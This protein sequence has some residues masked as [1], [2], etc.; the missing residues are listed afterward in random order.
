M[1]I[2]DSIHSLIVGAGFAGLYSLHRLRKLGLNAKIYEKGGGV[3]GTWYWNRYPGARCDIESMDYSYSF[4]KE[5]EQEWNWKNKYGTQPEILRYIDY[6]CKKYDLTKDI[7]FNVKIISAKYVNDIQKW[8]VTTN[9]S[10]TVECSFL[11]LATGNLSTPLMPK[12]RDRDKF[13][14]KIYHTGLWPSK[15]PIFR[16]RNVGVIGTGSS[17]IQ[18]IPIISES[19]EK[20][21]VFQKTANF[22][23]PARHTVLPKEKR[24][25]Y[26]KDYSKFRQLAR[27]SSFGIAKY[28]PPKQS[29]FD[30][31][32]EE[33]NKIY[34]RAW[35]EGGQAILFTF[36]DLLIDRKANE[37][38]C[39]FVRKKIKDTVE[40][41]RIAE[42]LCPN[43]H[44]IGTKRLCLD[45]N[46]YE[47]F[48]KSNVFLVDVSKNP[49]DRFTQDGLV[50]NQVEYQLDDIIFATGFNAI[51]GSISAIDITN[52]EGVSLNFYW[53]D[54][55]KTYL[56]IMISGFPNL[57]MITGPQSPGVKSQMILSI[58]QHV[59]FISN[60]ILNM[61]RKNLKEV[62]ALEDYQDQWVKHTNTVANSTLY[63]LA[64][65][66]YSG[67][68]IST[69][70]K[71][72]M[73]YVGG[74][75]DYKNICD[76][77]VNRK[78][79]GFNFS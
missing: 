59:D 23:I 22:S 1:K 2:D 26:K 38:A 14:G 67:S 33:R 70:R 68:N 50:V 60:L 9:L 55:P 52:G 28:Q 36:K 77:V 4:S 37:T 44:F 47:T 79:K 71:I 31:T 66:W 75:A 41:E 45:S 8:I 51:T 56:G 5:L 58:E 25:K 10:T 40:D 76:Q 12:I 63:P 21:Y 46:Y 24:E 48:N 53:R 64:R 16:N 49:I 6:V 39:E 30:V 19:A 62:S 78:Y 42:A 7:K 61:E 18:S 32:D 13:K 17:G 15:N 3:G 43:D 29:A 57:F 35:D 20:L 69:K 74:V 54:G 72:F 11:I 65:S 73:P 27:K 34:Q